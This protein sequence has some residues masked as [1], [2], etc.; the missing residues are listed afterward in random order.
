[1]KENNENGVRARGFCTHAQNSGDLA[2][3]KI[4]PFK[5]QGKA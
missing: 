3:A 4:Q 5:E 2:P 1:M